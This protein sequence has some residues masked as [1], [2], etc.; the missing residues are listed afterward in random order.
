V[1]AP[2]NGRSTAAAE[3]HNDVGHALRQTSPS[4]RGDGQDAAPAE[5]DGWAGAQA[6]GLNPQ[7]ACFLGPASAACR[8]AAC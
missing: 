8:H 4:G 7:V 2:S 3:D 1:A 5:G 6:A